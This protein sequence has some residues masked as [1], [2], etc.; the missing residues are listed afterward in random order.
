MLNQVNHWLEV[1]GTAVDAL[2]VLRILQLRLHRTYLYITLACVLS[3]F[4]DGI[5]LWFHSD[6]REFGRI[7]IYSRFLYI[8]VYPAAAHDVWEEVKTQVARIRRLATFRLVSSLL[9]A[10]VLGLIISGLAGSDEAGGEA[11]L[12][13]FG[14]ILWAAST[15]ASL[16]FLWS[17]HRL[18][19]A[20]KIEAPGNTAVWL[21]FYQ[22]SLSGEVVAC[23]LLII[24]QQFNSVVTTAID[25]SLGLYGIL[26]TLWCIWKL[27]ALP[28]DVSSAPENASL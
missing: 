5:M 21:L 19:R 1:A 8:F 15:T 13:T 24:D 20:Q 14:V 26:I 22:L 18:V 16:A 4:F 27:R 7:F 11:V 25:V 9:L 17:M 2:L 3:V 28:S 23:F 10:A 6:S 12:A